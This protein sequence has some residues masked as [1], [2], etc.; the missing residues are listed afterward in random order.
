M[1]N[2]DKNKTYILGK[3][4]EVN[5]LICTVKFDG[6]GHVKSTNW[7]NTDFDFMKVTAEWTIRSGDCALSKSK[8]SFFGTMFDFANEVSRWVKRSKKSGIF[9]INKGYNYLLVEANNN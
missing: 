6:N 4:G 7:D 3:L 9:D 5:T 1:L 2:L 8:T